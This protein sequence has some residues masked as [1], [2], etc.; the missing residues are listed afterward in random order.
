MRLL[1]LSYTSLL[2]LCQSSRSLSAPIPLKLKKLIYVH[3]HG[4]RTPIT[5]LSDVS[6]WESTLPD[7]FTRTGISSATTVTTS[8]TK[9]LPQSLRSSPPAKHKAGGGPVFGMLTSL[10][11]LQCVKLGNSIRDEIATAN[12]T[13]SPLAPKH[14]KVYST[15]FPRTITSVQALLTGLF[16]EPPAE[17]IAIDASYTNIMIPDPQ[18]R[19]SVEQAEL[20]KRLA[21]ESGDTDDLMVRRQ[22]A[23]DKT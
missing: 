17:P 7:Q 2:I 15:N 19:N 9:Y 20:E 23:S 5:P 21:A 16:P 11:I 1:S 3:R 4:D 6:F 14:V 18:P 8:S 10:G 13:T 22:D 12:L